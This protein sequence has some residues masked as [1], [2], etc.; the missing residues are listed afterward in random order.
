MANSDIYKF[1]NKHGI[2]HF[3]NLIGGKS[4]QD[5]KW[6][7]FSH[8]GV[9]FPPEY[10]K[11][12]IPVIYEGK[13][14]Q[15]NKLAEEYATIYAKYINTEYV[16]NKL[17]NKNFWNDWKKMLEKDTIIKTL[18]G[19]DFSK[20]IEHLNK[21]KEEKSRLTKEEK[22]M[23]KKKR[24]MEEEKYKIAYVDGEKQPVGNYKM[25]PPG[26]FLGR[27]EHPKIGSIKRR[28]N[29]EDITI[30]IGKEASIPEP[31]KG[32]K[33]HKIIHDKTLE[34]LASWKDN[35]TGKIKYVWLGSHSK[36][37]SGSDI[38]KFDLAR[39]LK[40][41]IREI[42]ESIN[43]DS[44]SFDIKKKQLASAL[45]LIDNFALR[46]GNEKG[47]DAADTV[48]VSSLRKEHITFS[49]DNTITLDFLGKDSVQY[50]ECHKIIPVIYNNLIEFT[51]NKESKENIF[52]EIDS[53]D[54]NKYLG[55]FMEG[56]TAKVFRTFNASYLFQRELDKI[57]K[58]ET[59]L[60][61]D[62]NVNNKL[63]KERIEEIVE[64]FN[65]AN[66]SVAILCNH[67]KNVAKT[68]ETQIDKINMKIKEYKKTIKKLSE[69]KKTMDDT[70]SNK[71]KSLTNKIAS[72][73]KKIVDSQRK[74]TIK[75]ELKNIS[76]DTS[77]ANYI[78]PRIV[79]SFIKKH[80]IPVD[81]VYT[82]TLKEKFKWALEDPKID[83]K[84]KF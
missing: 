36:F 27:G 41:K 66:L 45:Y 80:N 5:I 13:S 14:V 31:P 15:L 22:E 7:T 49:D 63:E 48:G 8:N 20:I 24:D 38:R 68:F 84:W 53:N 34:W 70:K 18:D 21:I 64:A 16:K 67:Q 12:N 46:V 78:D 1:I 57:K 9:S 23:I 3:M 30:N 72:L 10:V 2:E 32:H 81:K 58:I 26:I 19:C 56:L 54:I 62:G 4:K 25:E 40:T 73:K 33:W 17:F 65:K 55:E 47:E 59:P 79:S 82:K 52:D 42:R 60:D 83:D 51:D 71:Y 75:N 39:K 35:V 29:P 50:K 74:I 37:K 77:K 6:K 44:L 76:L 43:K 61:N 11:H 28:I 69:E